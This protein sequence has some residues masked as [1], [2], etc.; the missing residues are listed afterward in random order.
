VGEWVLVARLGSKPVEVTALTGDG[1]EVTV[2]AGALQL[3]VARGEVSPAPVAGAA[4][5]AR[6]KTRPKGSPAARWEQ[7]AGRGKG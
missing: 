6:A 5:A 7:L 4:A 2:R 3:R 1:R